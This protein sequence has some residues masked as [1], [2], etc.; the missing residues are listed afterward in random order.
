MVH[1]L[2]KWE[3]F[4]LAMLVYRIPSHFPLILASALKVE[5]KLI[6]LHSPLLV[7]GNHPN[8]YSNSYELASVKL[9]TKSNLMNGIKR[10]RCSSNYLIITEINL[11]KN[12]FGTFIQFNFF[13]NLSLFWKSDSVF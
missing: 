4:Q 13:N 12:I 6:N 11:N 9:S 5:D 8:T 2:L 3:I 10:K 7:A 1:F